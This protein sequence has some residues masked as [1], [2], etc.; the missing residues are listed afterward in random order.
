[1]ILQAWII[2]VCTLNVLCMYV[3]HDG[4]Y[5][6]NSTC[7][8]PH[9]LKC[10][11]ARKLDQSTGNSPRW[12]KQGR[13]DNNAPQLYYFSMSEHTYLLLLIM[14]TLR[15]V[16]NLDMRYV[17]RLREVLIIVWTWPYCFSHQSFLESSLPVRADDFKF[18]HFPMKWKVRWSLNWTM[19]SSNNP[20][21]S[22]YSGSCFQRLGN[23]PWSFSLE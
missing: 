12:I 6:L 9:D 21:V 13:P 10:E 17:G 5:E 3:L 16:M 20:K 23:T 19:L 2:S 15:W 22:K 1:M 14:N 18:L 11:S 7:I 8:W 4:Y